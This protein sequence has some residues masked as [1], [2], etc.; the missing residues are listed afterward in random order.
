MSQT[1]FHIV[2]TPLPLTQN[3]DALKQNGIE[4][5]Q[6]HAGEYWT[7]LNP[8]DP[9]ITILEQIC[10][11]LT[12]LGYCSTF[13][14]E[15]ILTDSNGEIKTKNQFYLPEQIL[16][17]APVT[18]T[19]Y[20]KYLIDGV[21]GL[22]NVTMVSQ[23]KNQNRIIDSYL[24]PDISFP[25]SAQEN[26]I[27]ASYYYLNN[28]RNL[29]L[30]FSQPVVLENVIYQLAGTITIESNV[31]VNTLLQSIS[32]AIRNYI[33][34]KVIPQGYPQ[35][36]ISL[37]KLFDGPYLKNGYIT[38]NSLGENTLSLNAYE[39]YNV[40]SGVENVVALSGVGFFQNGEAAASPITV[41]LSQ[42][43][44]IDLV[45]SVQ[46]GILKFQTTDGLSVSPNAYSQST[47]LQ[48]WPE[49]DTSVLLDAEVDARAFVPKGIYRDI[50]SY[51]SIQNTFPAIYPV[52]P[53]ATL[54]N[55][56]P[57]YIAQSRQ[58]KGYLS[59]FDQAIANQFS[60]LANVPDLFSFENPMTATPS[61]Q[62]YFYQKKT[63]YEKT[64]LEYPVPYRF[65]SPSYF[66]Q[67]LYE[68][69]NVRPLLKGFETFMFSETIQTEQALEESSWIQ[70]KED[71]YNPYIHG[72]YVLMNDNEDAIERRN[73]M[74]DHLLARHGESPVTIN[75]IIQ[76][77]F[78]T[79]QPATDRIIFKSLYLQNLGYLTYNRL[80]A[81]NFLAA[82]K[83]FDNWMESIQQYGMM[84]ENF[85]RED[86][87]ELVMQSKIEELDDI[88]T[89][90]IFNSGKIDRLEKL[91]ERDFVNYSAFELK[92]KLLF[93][94]RELY[95]EFIRE[96]FAEIGDP[97][98]DWPVQPRTDASIAANFALWLIT[99]R[100]GFVLIETALLFSETVNSETPTEASALLQNDLL[101]LFPDF[102]PEIQSTAFQNRFQF[103]CQTELPPDISC[104]ILFVSLG[105]MQTLITDFVSWH[106]IIRFIPENPPS[107][108]QIIL[109]TAQLIK[110]L[111]QIQSQQTK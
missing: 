37:D 59:L 51:Y 21:D 48:L 84:S 63:E 81:Y 93:G 4:F 107:P 58:L 23:R 64:H 8:S 11:A 77:S 72:L 32:L 7:N 75:T 85:K 90:F 89:D 9:G 65:F 55:K 102:V 95:A 3:F 52:G 17:T 108:F 45:G 101:I 22:D 103:Y 99:R 1:D 2:N 96:C 14:I 61:D 104:Q 86:Y 46:S 12:E 16:T 10:Y 53:N 71:P 26:L 6:Q 94:L 34:P 87:T 38:D 109:A 57:F 98:I 60:Q 68:V 106:N 28:S 79:H 44:D 5:I 91:T 73:V 31:D 18:E 92:A 43:L 83:I 36:S 24:L 41:N 80:K 110:T 19:D 35:F 27:D 40:I 15:D 74:L 97:T 30:R 39:L 100:S 33:F 62:A 67:S 82:D 13:S 49:F 50:N 56:N 66:Y 76:G 25:V 69:P 54:T 70:Y 105:E 88:T 42:L 47:Q 78:Y 20:R 29:C 111:T